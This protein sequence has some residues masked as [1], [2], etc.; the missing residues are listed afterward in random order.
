MPRH[1]YMGCLSYFLN[2]FLS[3]FC[4]CQNIAWETLRS[5][6]FHTVGWCLN[7]RDICIYCCVFSLGLHLVHICHCYHEEDMPSHLLVSIDKEFCILHFH[8]STKGKINQK[9]KTRR[10]TNY[11]RTHKL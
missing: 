10:K 9:Q 1:G 3:K 7:F 4:Q 6:Y 5:I 8:F 2:Q 11:N